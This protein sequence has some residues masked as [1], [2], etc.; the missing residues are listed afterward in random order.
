MNLI[1]T[2]WGWAGLSSVHLFS[3]QKISIISCRSSSC[4]FSQQWVLVMINK[5]FIKVM[6]IVKTN[7][8]AILVHTTWR[9]VRTVPANPLLWLHFTRPNLGCSHPYFKSK[10][11]PMQ[12]FP[13]QQN[14]HEPNFRIHKNDQQVYESIIYY[15]TLLHNNDITT[16]STIFK[17]AEWISPKHKRSLSQLPGAHIYLMFK[18]KYKN[19]NTVA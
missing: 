1:E 12:F 18:W 8:A 11:T 13:A 2:S 19:Y 10:H 14:A 4:K 5:V 6:T 16:T 17:G 7:C 15:Q 9:K 3:H